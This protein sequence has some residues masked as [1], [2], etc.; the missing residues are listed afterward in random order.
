MKEM[1]TEA[2]LATM[3]GG[4]AVV[5]CDFFTTWCGPCK[6]LAPVLA[7]IAEKTKAKVTADIEF[8]KAD[9]EKLVATAD[10]LDIRSIPTVVFFVKGKPDKDAI[11]GFCNELVYTGKI[12]EI[13]EDIA[14]YASK[15]DVLGTMPAVTVNATASK[16]AAKK[17]ATKKQL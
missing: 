11:V 1:E 17:K 3:I 5:V 16:P 15:M 4:H 7:G 2:E 12:D 14:G 6:A 10:A 8:C 13:L 9:C